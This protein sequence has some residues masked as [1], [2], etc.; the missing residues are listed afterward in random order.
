M[1]SVGAGSFGAALSR[2]LLTQGVEVLDVNCPDR[3]DRR[4]IACRLETSTH[5]ELLALA[6]VLEIDPRAS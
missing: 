3:T 6:Q 5:H 2:Y 1:A 4:Q